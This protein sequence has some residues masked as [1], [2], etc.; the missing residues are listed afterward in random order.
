MLIESTSQL[1]KVFLSPIT[2]FFWFYITKHS[3]T[4]LKTR[5]WKIRSVLAL[6]KR[7]GPE[8]AERPERT[9]AYKEISAPS[10]TSCW[11]SFCCGGL[12][13]LSCLTPPL[14]WRGFYSGSLPAPE[15]AKPGSAVEGHSTSGPY[16]PG[17][18]QRYSPLAFLWGHPWPFLALE[19]WNHLPDRKNEAPKYTSSVS[20]K[21]DWVFMT[22][23]LLFWKC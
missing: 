9:L 21:M 14:L 19:K 11:S 8:Q 12:S 23:S 17:F 1:S 4:H 16:S 10:W 20:L 7:K 5:T 22:P 2:H 3:R 18:V 6:Y 13:A 15:A